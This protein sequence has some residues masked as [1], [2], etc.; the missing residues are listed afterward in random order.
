MNELKELIPVPKDMPCKKNIATLRFS[1]IGQSYASKHCK[2]PGN[3]GPRTGRKSIDE[4]DA[5]YPESKE[6]S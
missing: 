1:A 2:N 5:G 3:N 6:D 4:L